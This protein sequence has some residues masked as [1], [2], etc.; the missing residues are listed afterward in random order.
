[1]AV[2]FAERRKQAEDAGLISNNDY[3]KLKEGDNRFRLMSECLPHNDVYQGKK[4]FKWLCYV[5]DRR[6]GKLK[7]FFMPHK[8]YKQIEA[9]Q[10]NEDYAFSDVPMPYDLTVNAVKAGTMDVVYTLLPARKETP[11]TALEHQELTK[12]APLADLQKK[13]LDKK[14][15]NASTPPHDDVPPVTDDDCPF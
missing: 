10:I 6:D 3:L 14:L 7:P 2:N 8:I 9:L 11:V 12:A 5:V 13:L 1:M 4:N 15:Q